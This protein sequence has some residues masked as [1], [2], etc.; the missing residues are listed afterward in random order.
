MMA[1]LQQMRADS[2]CNTI[3]PT[4]LPLAVRA[5][6]TWVT[7]GRRE[8]GVWKRQSCGQVTLEQEKSP[9][10]V[11]PDTP[12]SASTSYI[13]RVILKTLELVKTV[14]FIWTGFGKFYCTC[15]VPPVG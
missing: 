5:G 2:P 7:G 13:L 8:G 10:P 15:G 4:S 14:G 1:T 9:V 12:T 11:V 3:R 6:V